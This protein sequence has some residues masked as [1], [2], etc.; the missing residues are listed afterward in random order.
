LIIKP[1][2]AGLETNI[3]IPTDR[4]VYHLKFVSSEKNYVA[5]VAFN[6]PDDVKKQWA[7]ATAPAARSNDVFKNAADGVPGGGWS[8]GSTGAVGAASSVANMFPE[9]LFFDYDIE[10]SGA[11]WKPIRAFDDGQKTFIQVPPEARN[12]EIPAL[13]IVGADRFEQL[14]NYRYRDNYYVV[15]RIF[16]QAVLLI[17]VGRSQQKVT[18]TRRSAKRS[19]WKETWSF[20]GDRSRSTGGDN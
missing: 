11:P 13:M 5:R 18:I 4:R 2:E 16:D 8:G 17:G 15:D 19:S 3:I 1:R 20:G 9:R 14:V 7:I 10:G 6:Y 12:G